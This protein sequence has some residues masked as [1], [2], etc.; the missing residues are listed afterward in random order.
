MPV[1]RHVPSGALHPH[2]IRV[3]TQMAPNVLRRTQTT[4]GSAGEVSDQHFFLRPYKAKVGGS[5]PSAPT[6][7]TKV[8]E[9]GALC[10]RSA[11]R[12]SP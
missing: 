5:R 11:S 1:S 8:D 2:N 3:T 9:V 10:A 7:T 6:D 4:N 12:T